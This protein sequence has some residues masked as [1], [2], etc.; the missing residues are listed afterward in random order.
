MR[1]GFYGLDPVYP[2]RYDVSLRS[3]LSIVT[4]DE[5]KQHLFV[6]D[7]EN[8]EYLSRLLIVGTELAENFL[9]E[10]LTFNQVTA[11]WP[12]F[13]GPLLLPNRFID[14]VVSVQYVDSAGLLQV[15]PNTTWIFDNTGR[16]PV[17]KERSGQAFPDDLS[18]D[19]DNPVSVIYEASI[20]D[21]NVTETVK[22]AVLLYCAAFWQ[23]RESYIATGA[24]PQTLPIAAE[25]LLGPLKQ[26]S[27]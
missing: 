1:Y 16:F 24:V 2:T 4:L 23:S 26:V 14:S 19:L 21:S 8:D 17:V 9:G 11:Y 13:R 3:G 5:L 6:Y 10:F 22:Q 25:R 15:V 7:N 12:S 20:D 27:I 18:P